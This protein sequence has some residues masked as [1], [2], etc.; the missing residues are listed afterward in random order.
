MQNISSNEN[1]ALK[2]LALGRCLVETGRVGLG[3]VEELPATG[4]GAALLELCIL[5]VDTLS[6][7]DGEELAGAV[8]SSPVVGIAGSLF[9]FSAVLCVRFGRLR[10]LD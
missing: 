10:A 7:D 9:R 4:T 6:A 1:V 5:L 2:L 8:E 3:S